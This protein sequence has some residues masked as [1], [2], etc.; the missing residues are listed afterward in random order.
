MKVPFLHGGRGLNP[1]RLI[2]LGF[3][4]IILLG[5]LLLRLPVASRGGE[6]TS[7]LTCLFTATSATCV[8]GLAK[9]DTFLHWSWFGQLVILAL[10]Q[11]GGLGFITVITLV[12]LALR[13]RIGLSQRLMMASALN[14]SNTAGVVRVVRHALMG[15]F[16]LETGGALLLATRFI[17]RFG[18]ARGL[19]FSV[20]HSVSAFCNGGFDLMG[21]YTGTFSSLA[22]FQDDPVVLLTIM[23]LI[24][25]G[26]IGFFVWEDWLDHR[27]WKGL[28]LYS[29]LALAITGGMILLGWGFILWIEWDN[30]ATL[31]PM[32]P[33]EKA[34][35]A[36]F[37]SVT[38]R[39]AGFAT[40]D[41]GRLTD[42]AAV[43]SI[44]FMLV[45]G[46]SGST[47][48]GIK[49]VTAG[50]LLLAL[51]ESLRGKEQVVFRGRTIPARRVLDAM[52]LTLAVSLLLLA[53]AMSLSLLDGLPFLEAAYEVG[54]A[55]GTVGLSMGATPGLSPVSSLLIILFMYL[56]RVGILTFSIAFLTRRADSRLRYPT[57]DIMIG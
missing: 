24:V 54:S 29:K 12:S 14:L 56:G 8:T 18:P 9:V 21:E 35:N 27:C 15:T 28:S 5:T 42:S 19:W 43:F 22:G 25:V 34:L 26:G 55:L 2:A 3:G 17:P 52:T 10:L 6:C 45:G 53:G 23:I 39:T 1:T 48:G 30:P 13:R 33:W 20:F 7:W 37:Q 50:V 38:L 4:L 31:G 47:A 49:T 11:L 16:L 40:L 44:L 46:S 57:A 51:W 36:L 41:Q 32:P